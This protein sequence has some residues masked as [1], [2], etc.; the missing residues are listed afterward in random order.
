VRKLGGSAFLLM[1]LGVVILLS[2]PPSRRVSGSHSAP[3]LPRIEVIR[4][5]AAPVLHLAVDYFWIRTSHAVGAA[6]S[7]DQ[8]RDA[9]LFADLLT[10]LDPKFHQAYVFTG[11]ALPLNLGR[12]RWANTRESTAILEKGL[13]ILPHS[14][15]LRIVLAYNM[16]TFEKNFLR[17]AQLIEE[18]SRI[19]GAPGYLAPLATRLYARGGNID[20]GLELAKSLAESAS[21]PETRAVFELRV[22]QLQLERELDKVDR[23]VERFLTREGRV[24]SALGA[25][26]QSGDLERIPVDPLGGQILLD[27]QGRARSTS[28]SR[29]LTEFATDLQ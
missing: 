2:A 26:V 22:M 13:R 14:A 3:L 28:E 10:D 5:F 19:P 16:A 7:A 17:A 8:Y 12:G 11:T 4:I 6:S 21:D 27:P 29:R 1:S 23:A 15:F 20:A 9:Y 24:P 18:A 25:L